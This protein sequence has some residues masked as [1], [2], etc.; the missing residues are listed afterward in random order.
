MDAYFALEDQI[1]DLET[2]LLERLSNI[3]QEFQDGLAAL[4]K[5]IEVKVKKPLAEMQG[6]VDTE[7][8]NLQK[9]VTDLKEQADMQATTAAGNLKDTIMRS[10]EGA[11]NAITEQNMAPVVMQ[12][13]PTTSYQYIDPSQVEISINAAEKPAEP[14]T[15]QI[16]ETPKGEIATT[17]ISK[18]SK[19]PESP[20]RKITRKRCHSFVQTYPRLFGAVLKHVSSKCYKADKKEIHDF[21]SELTSHSEYQRFTDEVGQKAPQKVETLYRNM[22]RRRKTAMETQKS[23]FDC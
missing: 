11:Y 5:Q 7:K 6:Q 8:Q 16:E 14:T 22:C 10:L 13:T 17:S 15:D 18:E 3:R 9:M 23:G 2:H 12:S 19:V 20:P 21:I 1:N 4:E